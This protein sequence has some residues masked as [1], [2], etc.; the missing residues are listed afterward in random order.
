MSTT[1]TCLAWTCKS[2]LPTSATASVRFPPI[3]FCNAL[4]DLHQPLAVHLIGAPLALADADYSKKAWV[5]FQDIPA[6]HELPGKV[7]VVQGSVTSVDPASRTATVVDHATGLAATHEYDYFVAASGLRRVW[8]VVPQALGRKQYLLEAGEHIHTVTNARDG[9]VVVGGGAVGIEMAAELKM[10]KPHVSVTLVHS[11]DKLLSSEGLPDE[12]KDVALEL[13][14]EAGVEVLMEHRLAS[15]TKVE[16]ADG[17]PRY[18]VVFTNGKT[19]VASQVVMAM[20]KCTP[21]T[22]YLPKS[23]VNADGYV[24]IRPK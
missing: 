20:S 18:E 5:K 3:W 24:K 7:K 1:P 22:S 2:P 4:F 14:K 19:L 16:T 13:L 23:A 17:A 9:V 6:L 15:S 10:V 21:T 12:T 11:R 8:P